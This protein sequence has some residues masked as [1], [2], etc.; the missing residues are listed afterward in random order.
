VVEKDRVVNGEKITGRALKQRVLE[1]LRSDDLALGLEKLCQ[2]PARQVINPLFSFLYSNDPE[3]KWAAVTAMG[4]VTAK[5]ADNDMEA[6]RVIIRRLIWN[7]N[8]ESGGIGWG[9][10]EAMGEILAK[11]KGLAGEY[12]NILI[13]YAR[14]HGNYL[15]N[16]NLQHGLLWGI[17]RLS[18]AQP[19][20]AMEAVPHLIPYLKSRDATVRGLAVWTLGLLGVEEARRDLESLK[21]DESE[22]QIFIEGCLVKR[23]VRDLATDALKAMSARAI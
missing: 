6:A 21:T 3:I 4:A 20:T 12:A 5:L 19:K 14:E 22:I 10:P 11:Q 7:L 23:R 2:L 16:E 15:E 8:D 1:L 13:S 9:S 18:Q 17:G